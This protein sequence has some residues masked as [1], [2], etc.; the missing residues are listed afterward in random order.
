[1]EIEKGLRIGNELEEFV[2][3]HGD[4]INAIHKMRMN[5]FV[6][7]VRMEEITEQDIDESWKGI[8][9][10]QKTYTVEAGFDNPKFPSAKGT[11]G[12]SKN[13]YVTSVMN[14]VSTAVVSALTEVSAT[15]S[16]VAEGLTRKKDGSYQQFSIADMAKRISENYE[17]RLNELLDGEHPL[18]NLVLDK[19]GNV[20]YDKN[21]H[22]VFEQTVVEEATQEA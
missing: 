8:T 5:S 14:A 1:M 17:R 9:A 18:L 21:G 13:P 15:H 22:L 20:Q 10:L 2:N 4:K 6:E 11:N 3:V 16:I 12:S 7:L 19:D